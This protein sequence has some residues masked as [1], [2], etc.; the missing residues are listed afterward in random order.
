MRDQIARAM[1]QQL[2]SALIE[3][4]IV[5]EVQQTSFTRQPPVG[6]HEG[7]SCASSDGAGDVPATTGAP[8]TSAPPPATSTPANATTSTTP[9]NTLTRG[10]QAR[11][12]TEAEA[13]AWCQQLVQGETPIEVGGVVYRVTSVLVQHDDRSWIYTALPIT[14]TSEPAVRNLRW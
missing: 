1:D 2:P 3:D 12:F 13:V 5:D 11:V 9:G 7:P 4:P 10:W 6:A 8:A 14:A